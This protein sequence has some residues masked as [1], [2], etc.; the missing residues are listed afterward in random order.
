MKKANAKKHMFI[1][2]IKQNNIISPYVNSKLKKHMLIWKK[3]KIKPYLHME[4]SNMK[5]ICTYCCSRK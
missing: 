1:C 5:S 4:K 2:K 3:S